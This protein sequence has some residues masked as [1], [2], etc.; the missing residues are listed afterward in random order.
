[1]KAFLH[2][3]AMP[4]AITEDELDRIMAISLREHEVDVQML[5]QYRSK[6]LDNAERATERDGIAIVTLT[7][8]MF[9]R[10]NLFTAIS[11]A[12]SYELAA[13]DFQAALDNPAISGVMLKM[14]TPGGE[15]SGADEFAQM[16]FDARKRKPVYA[17]ISGMGASAGYWIASAAERIYVSDL[18]NVGSIGVIAG[19]QTSKEREGD[20]TRT[21]EFVSSQSPNKRPDME[22]DEGRRVM[23]ARV[24]EMAAV[25]IAAVAR[26][27]NV[28][29]E[30]VISKFGKGGVLI[31]ANAV[32]AGMADEVGLFEAAMADLK[33]RGSRRTTGQNGGFRMSDPTNGGE[34]AA[35]VDTAK[36][37]ADAQKAERGRI[38]AIHGHPHAARFPK[39]VAKMVDNGTAA[40]EA[41]ALLDAMA[42]DMPEKPADATDD[43]KPSE[44]S[45]A[46]Q[47]REALELGAMG[48]GAGAT[49]INP[50]AK[51]VEAYNSRV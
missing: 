38:A 21:Y 43:G 37:A 40:D 42:E 39:A 19:V 22:S 28:S 10:A 12:T 47:K 35:E 13:K 1:M 24:D 20:R 31:G 17:H 25:F 3:V 33:K 49:P 36:I 34:K 7:G 46:N 30:D 9:K 2:T 5:E 48:S 27:R 32:A 11:G 51:A 41:K 14:D 45:Y 23:Q 18:A 6:A 26:N 4:W 15:A 44:A 16:V 50:M 8:P 29:A